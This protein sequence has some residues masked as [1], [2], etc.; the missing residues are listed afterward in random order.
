[1][2]RYDLVILFFYAFL[3]LVLTLPLPLMMNEVLAGYDPDVYINPWADWWTKKAL[4]E[5][6]DFYHTDYLFYPRGASL[7]FHS[8]SH[9]NTAISLVLAPLVGRFAAYNVTVLLA[10]MLSGFN[11][12]LLA[13]WLTRCRPAAFIAGIVFAFHP[14]HVFESVH[15]VLFTVQ[16][17]PLFALALIRMLDPARTDRVRQVL[18]AALWFVLT[19]LSS[20][21]LMTMLAGWTILCLMHQL[22]LE[23]RRLAPN[24]FRFLILWVVLVALAM[25]PFLWPIVR[26]QLTTDTAYVAV[27]A[28]GRSQG[29]E[30][31]LL[32]FFLPTLGHPLF[33]AL[34][35]EI[36]ERIG[37][38]RCLRPA[39]LGYL[40]LAL[41]VCGV[42]AARR[43]T[44]FWLVGGIVSLLLSLGPQIRL[45]GSPLHS[46]SLPWA[47]PIIALLRHPVRL[48]I[49]LFFSLAVLVAFG[50]RW[51][52]GWVASRSKHLANIAMA[53]AAGLLL[54]EYLVFP[55]PYMRPSYS[56][57]LHQ[58][59][60]EEGD[61]AV[62]DVPMGRRPAKQ[63]MFYQTIHGHRIVGGCVS[64]TPD[65]AYAFVDAN[66]LLGLL[67]AGAVPDPTVDVGEQLAAL[68][69]AG[70]RYV[71]VHKD[72][73]TT[74]AEAPV[75]EA[76]RGF[77][78]PV[79][80]DDWLI[81]YRT[82]P[83][84]VEGPG[85]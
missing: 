69:A 24:F 30:N 82:A 84:A 25:G 56:P 85:D 20:W 47:I 45:N 1:M 60:G 61:F 71:I 35:P 3:T 16:W 33:G 83:E 63:Y 28:G 40:S 12:Y 13:S 38:L 14:Y 41:A 31:D 75:W 72:V 54:F 55:F 43:E 74:D 67:G 2:N 23:R 34:V 66:P 48:S 39:Y 9:T 50:G 77:L 57:F 4:T 79:Y 17:I 8:F 15:P 68:A 73:P 22:L 7:V 52:H 19:A 62:V 44:R 27:D 70:I 5:G 78:S 11:M 18:L 36:C 46:F 37:P 49:L 21:H 10:Y 26:E 29:V 32:S 64:R 65:D 81:V 76:P 59:A 51:L 53:L 58:L 6:L 42:A 80:E